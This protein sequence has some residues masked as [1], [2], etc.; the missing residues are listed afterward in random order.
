MFLVFASHVFVNREILVARSSEDK[1]VLDNL[2]LRKCVPEQLT[3]NYKYF[4]GKNLFEDHMEN[5]QQLGLKK[6]KTFNYDNE[7]P[8]EKP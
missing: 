7:S 4:K 6:S 2:M 1:A 5:F 3:S 8:K